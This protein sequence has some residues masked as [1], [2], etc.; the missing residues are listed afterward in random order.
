MQ[1]QS[2]IRRTQAEFLRL[3]QTPFFKVGSPRKSNFNQFEHR[4]GCPDPFRAKLANWK[5]TRHGFDSFENHLSSVGSFGFV[6]EAVTAAANEE[7]VR[8]EKKWVKL[9]AATA[10][11]HD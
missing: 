4:T 10:R 6:I 2:S 1:K 11:L 9:I 8:A 3:Y 5:G 7:L